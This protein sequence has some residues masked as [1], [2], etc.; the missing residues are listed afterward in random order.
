M[1][2]TKI[3][4]T[5][6]PPFTLKE[7]Q[8]TTKIYSI[9]G[10]IEKE[11]SLMTRRRPFRSPHHTISDAALVDGGVYLQPGEIS[12]AYGDLFLNERPEF[13]RIVLEMMRQPLEYGVITISR[14]KS[15]VGYPASLAVVF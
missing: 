14:A 10:K 2:Y 7:A 1:P 4:P 15:T 5:I 3:V 13:K 6:L 9:A 8:E 12:L 11:I